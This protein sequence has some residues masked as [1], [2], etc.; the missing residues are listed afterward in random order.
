MTIQNDIITIFK[1]YDQHNFEP[2]ECLQRCISYLDNTCIPGGECDPRDNIERAMHACNMFGF[3]A[4]QFSANNFPSAAEH[5][6]I[7]A[8]NK[9]N[10]IQRSEKQRIYKAGISMHL[11]KVY[12]KFGDKGGAFRWALLTQAD[13]ILGEHPA[14]GGAGRQMLHTILGMSDK[15]IAD[16]NNVASQNVVMIRERYQNDWS[17]PPSFGEDVITRFALNR[18][19]YSHLFSMSS[20]VYEYPLCTAYF[21]T[22]LDLINNEGANTR[23]KGDALEDLA[24]YLFLLIPGLV[25]RR[26]LLDE[27]LAYETDI[28]VR[29]LNA[30]SSLM[31]DLIGRH[32][33][34]ECKNWENR[35][36]VQN[37]GYFLYRMHLT[38]SSFGVMFAKSGITGDEGAERA[39]YSLIRKSFHEDGNVCVVVDFRDFTK[40][41]EES[42]SFWSIL[43]ERIERMRFGQA[44]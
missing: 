43:L 1:S 32:F 14:G 38:H 37:I 4:H 41:M 15:A 10:L 20:A 5:I 36:G 7:D 24:S 2:S 3:T 33:L 39:A 6:L 9:F 12:L 8:W 44:R 35:V 25:P 40:L 17:S 34:V 29:N 16:F 23:E 22:L 30:N 18:P 27:T 13:D 28:A 19:E 11:A 31:S 26:N 42:S 21:T